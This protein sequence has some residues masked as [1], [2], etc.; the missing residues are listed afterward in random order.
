MSSS[1]PE[2][3]DEAEGAEAPPLCVDLDGTLLR[4]DTLWECLFRL[5]RE[6]P[7]ELLRVPF[8]IGGGRAR[9]KRSLA[10]RIRFPAESL[11][12]R[13][14]VLALLREERA[15]GRRL[16]LATAAHESIAHAVADHTGVFDAVIAS[17]GRRNLKG[18]AKREAILAELGPAYDYVGNSTADL[19]LWQGA[20]RAY[21]ADPRPGILSRAAEVCEPR[22]LQGEP[23]RTL[24]AVLRALRPHQ[25]S[26]NVLLLA[27]VL[28]AHRVDE[29]FI[30]LQA[31]AA[32]LAFSLVASAGYVVNDLLDL[33]GDRRHP[34]K[35]SRPFASG[36][37]PVQAGLLLFVGLVSAGAALSLAWLN[38]PF[39]GMLAAYLALT[40][41]YSLYFKRKLFVDV[42][43]LAGL[44]THRVL[45]GGI[46]AEV[47]V[48]EWMLAFS[49]FIFLSLAF[50]KRYTELRDLP[51]GGSLSGRNYRAEDLG[52]IESLGPTCGYLAVLVFALY[53]R[54]EDAM[55]LYARPDLLWAI[56]PLLLLWISRVWFLAVR[57]EL[58]DDPVLFA[59]RDRVS[60][61]VGALVA[62]VGVAAV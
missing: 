29:P 42:L 35:K 2:A 59:I 53:I 23:R 8:W 3:P 54:S 60:Y 12:Y 20:R 56:C 1:L 33:E 48:S 32:V 46:A 41:S 26:K 11:P 10:E 19:P 43:I 45:A 57:G 28:L 50:A 9:F 27:P 38:L 44:Y 61:A 30:W 37:L 31:L 14:E 49:I 40:L 25:W 36:A 51:V 47:A 17:D 34:R 7:L 6:R 5:A 4:T 58:S 15:R 52:L 24:R 13:E 39:L 18:E 21:V 16:V 62:A 22:P 55:G